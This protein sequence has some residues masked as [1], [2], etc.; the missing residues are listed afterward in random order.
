[1]MMMEFVVSLFLQLL[2][3]CSCALVQRRHSGIEQHFSDAA[4]ASFFHL[5]NRAP[6]S[7]GAPL[8]GKTLGCNSRIKPWACLLLCVFLTQKLG[9][10]QIYFNLDRDDLKK[11]QVLVVVCTARVG[12]RQS[13]LESGASITTQHAASYPRAN[14]QQ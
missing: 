12:S 4:L 2:Q 7:V 9:S 13:S 14:K 5:Y 6:C 1:M 11:A 8:R 3:F 10:G